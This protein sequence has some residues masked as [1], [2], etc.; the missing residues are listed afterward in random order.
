[1]RL[2][3]REQGDSITMWAP[4]CP[5]TTNCFRLRMYDLSTAR[6][7]EWGVVGVIVINTAG[8]MV[9][10]YEMNSSLEAALELLNMVCA[11][12]CASV[13]VSQVCVVLFTLEAGIKITGWGWYYFKDSWCQFDFL[14][15]VVSLI[16]L[17]LATSGTWS[18]LRALR[19]LRM[20]RLVKALPGLQELFTTLLLSLPTLMNIGALVSLFVF[21][22]GCIGMSLFGKVHINRV[23]LTLHQTEIAFLSLRSPTEII[24]RPTS[25]SVSR[26]HVYAP[27][28]HDI[29][30][31]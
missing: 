27:M 23:L 20:I 24:S 31:F 18:A 9:V 13:I 19:L 21:I 4:P 29:W 22:W 30:L 15:V 12:G 5:K 6:W 1:M 8:L 2:Q 10:H 26:A 17:L 28:R 16:S 3:L 14:V 11:T 25:T 7:F